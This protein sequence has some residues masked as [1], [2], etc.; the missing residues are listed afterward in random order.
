MWQWKA[1]DKALP[2]DRHPRL[3]LLAWYLALYADLPR[4]S[5]SE[6]MRAHETTS[7]WRQRDHAATG[8]QAASGD[9][10]KDTLDMLQAL[11][12]NAGR[13]VE[14]KV[15][16]HAPYEDVIDDIRRHTDGGAPC[17]VLGQAGAL[18]GSIEPGRQ[19]T[20]PGPAA[21]STPALPMPRL[22]YGIRQEGGSRHIETLDLGRGRS[23][24]AQD[25]PAFWCATKGHAAD[26]DDDADA[27]ADAADRTLSLQVCFFPRRGRTQQA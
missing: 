19:L 9:I 2:V 17:L 24:L 27:D 4:A 10:C 11:A 14:K 20:G 16:T 26:V 13:T 15:Y 25:T 21:A 12:H 8:T 22:V 3:L 6:H 23:Y 1:V 7:C 18:R 5:L